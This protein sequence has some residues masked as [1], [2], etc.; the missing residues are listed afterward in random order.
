MGGRALKDSV[1]EMTKPE[2]I[3]DIGDS[4]GTRGK[5]NMVDTTGNN[6]ADISGTVDVDTGDALTQH[7]MDCTG[8]TNVVWDPSQAS[9]EDGTPP[10]SSAVCDISVQMFSRELE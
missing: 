5:L 3:M 9:V 6:N 4:A 8:K 1:S 10:P 2:I 7:G